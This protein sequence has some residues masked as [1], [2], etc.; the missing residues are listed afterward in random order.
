[1]QY[2]NA[3]RLRDQSSKFVKIIFV[4][5]LTRCVA[6][7]NHIHTIDI[8]AKDQ[9]WSKLCLFG[10]R[11]DPSFSTALP[12]REQ[13]S[14]NIIKYKCIWSKHFDVYIFIFRLSSTVTVP[15]ESF[16]LKDILNRYVCWRVALGNQL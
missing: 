1:M 11:P 13:I 12:F 15:L 5:T 14:C 7:N 4:Q 9:N 8:E 3:V 10:K 2:K 16:H 6:Q